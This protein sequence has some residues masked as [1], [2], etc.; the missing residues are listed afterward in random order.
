MRKSF[1]ARMYL[2]PTL[3]RIGSRKFQSFVVRLLPWKTVREVVELTDH[4]HDTAMNIINSRKR[5]LAKGKE[6]MERQVG[7]GKD[8]IS[9]L[10]EMPGFL[11]CVQPLTRT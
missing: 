7:R 9:I 11:S 2:L 5:A 10:C 3:S 8:I 4:L 1:F 6:T